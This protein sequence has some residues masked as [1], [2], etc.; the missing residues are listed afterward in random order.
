MSTEVIVRGD[1]LPVLGPLTVVQASGSDL[2]HALVWGLDLG[3]ERS[4]HA[5][6]KRLRRVGQEVGDYSAAQ[7]GLRHL[8]VVYSHGGS[9]PE[10]SCLGAAAQAATRLHAEFERSRGREIDV[11][12][13]DVTGWENGELFRDRILEAVDGR[14]NSPGDA[15]L[16]WH[17]IL[18]SSIH[19][20]AMNQFY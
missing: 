14:H 4:R 17:D 12:T 20:A 5:A 1:D 9:L 11:I 8:F 13:V 2:P 19:A 7:P 16:G 10:G 3:N 15:A 18:D 6:Q